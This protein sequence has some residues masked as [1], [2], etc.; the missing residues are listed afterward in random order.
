MST[1]TI[2]ISESDKK[3]IEEIGIRFGEST[4]SIIHQAIEEYR[5]R[6]LL[7]EANEAYGKMRNDP[8]EWK[9]EMEEREDW[10]A[11]AADG[12]EKYEIV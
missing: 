10:D 3:T 7:Q 11:T 8:N 4:Q 6:R 1:K 5:R 9:T 12:L 2:R